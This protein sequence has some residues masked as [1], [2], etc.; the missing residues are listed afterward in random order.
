MAG[1][2]LDPAR[3]GADEELLAGI[4]AFVELHIEQGSALDGL[5]ARGRGRRGHLAARPLA[6]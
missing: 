1:A 6:A 3:L 5:G 2:G 4:G